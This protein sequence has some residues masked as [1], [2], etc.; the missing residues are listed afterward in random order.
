MF[1]IIAALCAAQLILLII[2]IT[3]RQSQK[4]AL[5]RLAGQLEQN[6]R[7]F[8]DGFAQNR[9]EI[10]TSARSSREEINAAFF[11]FTELLEGKLGKLENIKEAVDLSGKD[12]R[13]DLSLALD[14]FGERFSG[15]VREFTDLQRE[16]FAELIAKQDSLARDTRDILD[17]IRDAVDQRLR[18]IQQDNSAKLERMRETVDEKLHQTLDARLGESFKTVREQLERV[19]ASMG[20]MRNLAAS[21]GDLNRVMSNVKARGIWGEYQ[22]ESLLEEILTVNQYEKN[23]KTKAGSNDMVEFAIKLPSREDPSRTVWLPLDAKFPHSVFQKLD[24]ACNTGNADAVAKCK[25]ELEQTI[26]SFAKD[27]KTKYVDPPHTTDFAIMFLPIESLFSEVLR[28]P[29][30]FETVLREQQVIITG[31]TTLSAYLSSLKMGFQALE[32]GRRS[33]EIWELLKKVQSDF[34]SFGEA[35]EKAKKKVDDAGKELDNA[36]VKSRKIEKDLRKVQ[37]EDPLLPLPPKQLA[38]PPEEPPLAE[39]LDADDDLFY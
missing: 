31:P 22:L 17:K 36:G 33:G 30:L 2:I 21:V 4:P 25:K 38:P 7:S 28:R 29:D 8:K 16:K 12:S 9:N 6:E 18:E 39:P 20:E 37:E 35:L 10:H 13:R 23:V 1:I 11:N 15:S 19:Q 5:E 32:V 14:S 26:K 3:G 27:I 34:K 24:D